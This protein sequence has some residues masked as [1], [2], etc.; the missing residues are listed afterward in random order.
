MAPKSVY[1]IIDGTDSENDLDDAMLEA[2]GDGGDSS[3]DSSQDALQVDGDE[4]DSWADSSQDAMQVDGDEGDSSS[5]ESDGESSE[6]ESIEVEVQECGCDVCVWERANHM[7]IR[8]SGFLCF[9]MLLCFSC[10]EVVLTVSLLEC[11]SQPS[12][13]GQLRLFLCVPHS[14]G[15][16]SLGS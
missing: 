7:V 4:G 9:L 13:Q 10:T 3:A 6:D 14:R 12:R 11:R 1:I 16:F 2:Q 15:P 5:A 8:G